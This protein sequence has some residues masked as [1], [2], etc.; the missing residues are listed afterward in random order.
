MSIKLLNKPR[1]SGKTTELIHASEVTG[2]PIITNNKTQAA[3]IFDSAQKMGCNIEKP[4]TVSELLSTN[5]PFNYENVLID[6]G[7]DIISKAL[8]CYLRSHVVAV[9]LTLN[10]NNN[11]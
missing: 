4:M 10:D 6:E 3:Y 1:N 8:D 5:K 7:L 2:Y 11:N 9:T